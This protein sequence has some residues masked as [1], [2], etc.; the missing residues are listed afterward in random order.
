MKLKQSRYN[1]F[2]RA[3]DGAHLAFNAI[4]GG[5]AKIREVDYAAFQEILQ[6]PN[7]DKISAKNGKEIKEALTKGNFLI[8]EETNELDILKAYNRIARFSDTNLSLAIVP[9]MNCNFKC[10]YCYAEKEDKQMD[11]GTINAILKLVQHRSKNIRKLFITWVGG[12]PLLAFDIVEFLSKAFLDICHTN[13]IEYFSGLITNGYLLVPTVFEQL[14]KLGIKYVQ[15]TI[16]GPRDTHNLRRPLQ[17]G[18]PTFDKILENLCALTSNTNDIEVA[19]RINIDKK[20]YERAEEVIDVLVEKK[21]AQRITVGPAMVDAVTPICR[22]IENL[23]LPSYLFYGD[24]LVRFAQKAMREGLKMT[25][26]PHLK[27][28]NCMADA[29]NAY[30]I[31]CDGLLY[32]CW[33]DVGVKSE[34]VGL[35]D[36]TGQIKLNH[37]VGAWLAWDPFELKE[38]KDC[39]FLPLCLGG[40][41]YKRIRNYSEAC[42]G[43]KYNL[44]KMLSLVYLSTANS[45]ISIFY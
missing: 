30:I 10:Y 1:F 20:N 9:N 35:L 8:D 33:N 7:A 28:S 34:S 6:N 44:N 31:G 19:V 14:P 38:C 17:N 40:C 11:D 36:N 29:L 22:N 41:P 25:I 37:R 4:S 2:L 21:L 39:K 27:L 15:V 42:V 12:E 26:L 13:D 5:F 23:C 18:S 3:E 45:N 16:D 43:W 24:I 32:K